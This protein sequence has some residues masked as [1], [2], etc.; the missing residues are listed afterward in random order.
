L[1]ELSELER[2]LLEGESQLAEKDTRRARATFQR[3][4]EKYP[5]VPRA[6]Y[7]LGVAVIVDG[8]VDR[9][10]TLLDQVV[11]ELSNPAAA[12]QGTG[13]GEEPAAG[14]PKGYGPDPRTL[15]WAHV[16]LGRIYEE[17]GRREQA[18][19][20]YRAALAVTG[21][22]EGARTAAQRGLAATGSK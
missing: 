9:G 12:T 13:L 6:Q 14:A 20:E 18:G 22:P 15:A 11:V 1:R 2:W 16:W 7:G 21:A 10:R 3:V 19:V 8:E 5:D 4:L 17:R